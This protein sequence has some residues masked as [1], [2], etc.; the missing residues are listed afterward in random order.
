MKKIF[1]LSI[2]LSSCVTYKPAQKP[3]AFSNKFTIEKTYEDTWSKVINFFASKNIPIKTIEKASGLVATD[4]MLLNSITDK[5]IFDCGQLNAFGQSTPLHGKASFNVFIEKIDS[6]KTQMTININSNVSVP[7]SANLP[8][9]NIN[10][11]SI[12]FYE[13]EIFDFVSL[14]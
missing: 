5:N 13:K 11:Y 4:S 9:Q 12:G 2:A 1:L 3:T 8:P 14:K 7:M 10:C 6:T